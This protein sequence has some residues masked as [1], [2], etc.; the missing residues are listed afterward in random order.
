MTGTIAIIQAR[1]SSSRLPGKVLMDI[2]GQP[3]LM[4][5][6]ERVNHLS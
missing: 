2:G 5:V 1:M 6:I 4:R 3:M